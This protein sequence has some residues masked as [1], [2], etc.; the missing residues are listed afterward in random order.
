[1]FPLFGIW[2]LHEKNSEYCQQMSSC[3]NITDLFFCV[4]C[5]GL[6]PTDLHVPAAAWSVLLPQEENPPQRPK[7]PEPAHQR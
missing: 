1:M 5:L 2:K 7:A 6:Y 4:L 3:A